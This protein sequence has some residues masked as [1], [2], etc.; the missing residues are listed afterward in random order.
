MY[1]PR[2]RS[3]TYSFALLALIDSN[4]PRPLCHYRPRFPI[5]LPPACA[6]IAS[7]LC[8]ATATTTSLPTSH[9]G[10]TFL[11][12]S[13]LT[14]QRHE[15]FTYP[16]TYLPHILTPLIILWLGILSFLYTRL[17]S[18]LHFLV[19]HSYHLLLTHLPTDLSSYPIAPITLTPLPRTPSSH[20]LV[21]IQAR[22]REDVPFAYSLPPLTLS[23]SLPRRHLGRTPW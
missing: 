8:A 13:S 15:H 2:D 22:A 12:H 7:L 4:T 23:L 3:P 21:H 20:P 10:L 1:T 14:G 11:A 17:L 16:Y 18:P 19:S 9:M 6:I 5:Q